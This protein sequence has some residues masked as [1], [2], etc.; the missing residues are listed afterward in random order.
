MIT[1]KKKIQE[2]QFNREASRIRGSIISKTAGKGFNLG[3]SPLAILIDNETNMQF[4]KAVMDYN[5]DVERNYAMSG[6]TNTRQ[7]GIYNARATRFS[8]YSNAFSQIL[9]TGATLGMMNMNPLRLK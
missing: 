5:T 9:N 2:Y 7:Q 1:E 4:D 6:A 8:G 3:G